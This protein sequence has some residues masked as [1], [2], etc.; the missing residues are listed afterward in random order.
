MT[1]NPEMLSTLIM[2]PQVII[3]MV[4]EIFGQ[5]RFEWDLM[6]NMKVFHDQTKDLKSQKKKLAG[7]SSPKKRAQ[8]FSGMMEQLKTRLMNRT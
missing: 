6:S 7:P 1:C 2:Y 4:G 3:E 8:A 5:D